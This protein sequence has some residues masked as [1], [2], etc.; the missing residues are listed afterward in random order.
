MIF[1][2]NNRGMIIKHLYTYHLKGYLGQHLINISSPNIVQMAE[3]YHRNELV[4]G[5][6]KEKNALLISFLLFLTL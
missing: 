6:Y 5:C 4:L 2:K 1:T 3:R